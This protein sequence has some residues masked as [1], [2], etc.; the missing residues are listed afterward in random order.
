MLPIRDVIPSRTTPWVVIALLAAYATASA[1]ALIDHPGW[2]AVLANVVALAVFGETLE[3]RLGH[4][5]F[6]AF[7]LLG[8]SAAVAGWMWLDLAAPYAIAAATG[9][10]ASVLGGYLSLFPRSRVLVFVVFD[11]VELPALIV[12]AFWAVLHAVAIDP[13]GA[14]LLGRS[15]FAAQMIGLGVGAASV[16]L[17]RRRE[18]VA[19]AW[20][21]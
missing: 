10:V 6:L 5:R 3:D 9:G 20:W 15:L 11:V 21:S 18:R 13:L 12:V 14:A 4:G 16:R 8:A 7:G 1:A 17:F 2:L 19:P